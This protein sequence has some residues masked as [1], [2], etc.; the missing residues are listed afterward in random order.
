MDILAVQT[1]ADFPD[2]GLLMFFHIFLFDVILAFLVLSIA[3]IALVRLTFLKLQHAA[4]LDFLGCS[5]TVWMRACS[6]SLHACMQA[7]YYL[8]PD[9][10]KCFLLGARTLKVGVVLKQLKAQTFRTLQQ[11]VGQVFVHPENWAYCRLWM[12]DT[13]GHGNMVLRYSVYLKICHSLIN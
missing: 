8:N 7:K 11:R 1:I 5:S 4:G 10:A 13:V 6:C 2:F 9:H 12:V 3:S